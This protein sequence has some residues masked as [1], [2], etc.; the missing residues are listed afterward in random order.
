MSLINTN[1]SNCGGSIKLDDSKSK[2]F[3]MHCGSEINIENAI[4]SIQIDQSPK[5]ANLMKLLQ[6][7]KRSENN[8]KIE[9]VSDDILSIDQEI[10]TVWRYKAYGILRQSTIKDDRIYEGLQSY[11]KSIEV[12]QDQNKD[13]YIKEIADEFENFFKVF[14][15]HVSKHFGNYSG[16]DTVVLIEKILEIG[17]KGFNQLKSYQEK[18]NVKLDFTSIAQLILDNGLLNAE[19]KIMKIDYNSSQLGYILGKQI[20]IY[21]ANLNLI[22]CLLIYSDDINEDKVVFILEKAVNYCSEYNKRLALTGRKKE[23]SLKDVYVSKLS[24]LRPGYVEPKGCYVATCVYG[25]YNH[26]SVLVLRKYRDNK[27][28]HTFFGRAFIKL[29]Y[30]FSPSIVTVFGNQKWFTKIFKTI[31]D[32]KVKKLEDQ[33]YSN[34]KYYE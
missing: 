23:P 11:L 3:C 4:R 25:D 9:K 33:G 32:K 22:N 19:K 18:Q 10:S 1:C 27:L 7:A 15:I 8:E 21:A 29:Y 24:E 12:Y 13:E 2:G 16:S 34:F 20:D 28:R 14:I 17:N 26:S 31:L 6:E 30:K 5:V